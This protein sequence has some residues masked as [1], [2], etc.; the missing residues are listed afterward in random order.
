MFCANC[1]NPLPENCIF[2]PSCG[3]QL[4]ELGK[5]PGTESE[6]FPDNAAL[7]QPDLSANLFMEKTRPIPVP[8]AIAPGYSPV[9]NTPEF[10]A[11]IKRFKKATF[12]FGLLISPLPLAG[13]IIY[14]LVNPGEMDLS[15]AIMVGAFISLIFLLCAVIPALRLKYQGTWDGVVVD[16]LIREERKSRDESFTEE[17]YY[18]I[19]RKDTGGKATCEENAMNHAIYDYLQMGERVRFHPE[20]PGC[21]YEKYDKRGLSYVICGF[22][23]SRV[24]VTEDFCPGCHSPVLK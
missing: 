14:S 16:K 15:T 19:I 20:L 11:A 24:K 4:Q 13:F 8:A 7:G 23:K 6:Q 21:P 18:T 3:T 10:Q 22:C 9:F 17:I 5:R 12:G 1:G 2:C